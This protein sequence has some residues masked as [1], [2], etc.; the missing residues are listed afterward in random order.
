MKRTRS[1]V[2]I[3][4]SKFGPAERKIAVGTQIALEHQTMKWT[5]HGLD[6]VLL[7]FHIHLIKHVGSVELEMARSLPQINIRDVG[8]VNDIVSVFFVRIFPEIFDDTA[9]LG[10]LGMPKN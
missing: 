1:L 6:L 4:C 7:V 8:S 2:T 3:H 9:D 5:I 10:S